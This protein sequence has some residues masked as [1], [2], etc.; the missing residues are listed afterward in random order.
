[1]KKTMKKLVI[2]ML[3]VLLLVSVCLGLG[4]T[5]SASETTTKTYTTYG[6]YTYNG[7]TVSGYPSSYFKVTMHSSATSG[8]GTL[9]TNTL[10]NWSYYQIRVVDVD[11]YAHK[12]FKLYRNG[13]LYSSKTLSGTGDLTLYSRP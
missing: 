5:A 7:N 1:M 4:V 13:S 8:V 11:I 6:S 12:S 3:S 2:S 10:T 9:Y